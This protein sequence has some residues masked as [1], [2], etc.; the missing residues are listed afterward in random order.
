MRCDV[1]R[2]IGGT[3]HKYYLLFQHHLP[4]PLSTYTSDHLDANGDSPGPDP[5]QLINTFVAESRLGAQYIR[6]TKPGPYV[7]EHSLN[8]YTRLG[9]RMAMLGIDA[10]TEVSQLDHRNTSCSLTLCSVLDAKLTTPRR[11]RS[12]SRDFEASL[13]PLL[14]LA[15]QSSI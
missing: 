5:N 2:G 12:F 7:A 8:M 11:T 6:G 4:P 14:A 3:A 15:A 13:P 9:A 1:F 10:R